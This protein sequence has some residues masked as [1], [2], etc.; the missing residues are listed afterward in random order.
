MLSLGVRAK[1]HSELMSSSM[2][3]VWAK[4]VESQTLGMYQSL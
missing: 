1:W 4:T 3:R 2:S